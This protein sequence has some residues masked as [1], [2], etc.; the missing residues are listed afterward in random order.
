MEEKPTLEEP[1][2]QRGLLSTSTANAGQDLLF[3]ATRGLCQPSA[4]QV[5]LNLCR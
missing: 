1:T 3:Q 5:A 4:P 2:F